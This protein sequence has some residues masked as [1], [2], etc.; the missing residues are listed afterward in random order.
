MLRSTKSV[1]HPNARNKTDFITKP[2][3]PVKLPR[4]GARGLELGVELHAAA[5]RA[6]ASNPDP[7]IGPG[8]ALPWAQQALDGPFER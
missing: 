4:G 8:S 3:I 1:I 6:A 2:K 5:I 7:L